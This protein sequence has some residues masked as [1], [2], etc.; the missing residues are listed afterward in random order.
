MP[1]VPQ[2]M[3][4]CDSISLVVAYIDMVESAEESMVEVV[5][6]SVSGLTNEY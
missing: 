2:S 1:N 4:V 6:S 3:V 5:A